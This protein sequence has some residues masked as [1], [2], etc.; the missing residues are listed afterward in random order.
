M[1]MIM[2]VMIVI[3]IVECPEEVVT[4]NKPLLPL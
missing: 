1:M 4:H 2:A 3:M